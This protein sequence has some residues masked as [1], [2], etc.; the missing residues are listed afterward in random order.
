MKL[1]LAAALALAITGSGCVVIDGH[2]RSSSAALSSKQCPPGHV[3]SDGS[4]HTKG[5]GHER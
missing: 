1:V 2:H 5:K 3:W 4:C